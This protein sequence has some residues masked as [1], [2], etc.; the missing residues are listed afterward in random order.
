MLNNRD[1]LKARYQQR[2]VTLKRADKAIAPSFS[3]RFLPDIKT[4]NFKGVPA[5]TLALW[6]SISASE[7]IYMG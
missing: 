1:Y 2:T 4:F 6:H 5:A 7:R 3:N